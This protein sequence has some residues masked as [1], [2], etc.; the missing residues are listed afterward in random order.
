MSKKL[1]GKSEE[2]INDIVAELLKNEDSNISLTYDDANDQFT[3]NLASNVAV[4]SFSAADEL[5]DPAGVSHTGE[6]ADVADLVSD[7]DNL[8]GVSFGDHHNH[9]T[10]ATEPSS[11]QV[12]ETWTDT[13]T[14]VHYVYADFGGG[15]DWHPISPVK[16]IQE[17][18]TFA[19]SNVT[20]THN[21]TTLSNGS[22]MLDL[23]EG[24]TTSRDADND[25]NSAT[26]GGLTINPNTDLVGV[27]VAVSANTS[28]PQTAEIRDSNHNTLT[29]KDVSNLSA[30][31]RF[32]LEAALSSGTK[33]YLVLSASTEGRF[34]PDAA[35]PYT[36]TDLDITYG[37]LNDSEDEYGAYCLNDVTGLFDA[38][39]G[40][41]LISWDSGVPTDNEEWVDAGYQ[42]SP[43]GETVT[44]D[45]EDSSG[46]VLESNISQGYP[47]DTDPDVSPLDD[48]R[49]RVN[50]SRADTS[51]NPTADY[52]Y[53]RYTR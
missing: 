32:R 22:V 13:D 12:G 42:I 5:F 15:A 8:S 19:E 25:S 26:N 44:I 39:S 3:L 47:L 9:Y 6:L 17:A 34:Y 27:E 52:L 43:D 37:Y 20:V 21:K 31:D 30:G 48:I 33:Y 18:S 50:L 10:Q 29:S 16:P 45:V 49:L 14:G 51:N 40:D 53:R 4:D 23:V 35:W 28:G 36:G 38:T 7:H 2:Q 1:L 11:P 41:A 24:A 46:N